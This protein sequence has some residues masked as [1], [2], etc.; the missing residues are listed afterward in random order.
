MKRLTFLPSSGYLLPLLLLLNEEDKHNM[1]LSLAIAETTVAIFLFLYFFLH[2]AIAA[3]MKAGIATPCFSHPTYYKTK[4]RH[5]KGPPLL[6]GPP[7]RRHLHRK[8]KPLYAIL[9]LNPKTWMDLDVKRSSPFPP[10]PPTQIRAKPGLPQ[11]LFLSFD[12]SS[13]R[14]DIELLPFLFFARLLWMPPRPAVLVEQQFQR[15][16]LPF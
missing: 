6:S 11:R 3:G 16:F 4:G 14:T 15:H 5:R 13:S 9:S 12:V 7:S 2:M 1:T 8:S 10:L